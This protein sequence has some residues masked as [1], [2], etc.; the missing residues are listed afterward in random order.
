ME[1]IENIKHSIKK[2]LIDKDFIKW[3]K[4]S[5]NLLVS[6]FE[7]NEY[8]ELYNSNLELLD[9][10]IIWM[11]DNN[12]DK[13]EFKNRYSYDILVELYTLIKRDLYYDIKYNYIKQLNNFEQYSNKNINSFEQYSNKNI[14]SFEQN[15]NNLY[16]YD[17]ILFI[18]FVIGLIIIIIIRLIYYYYKNNNN[19]YQIQKP[20]PKYNF[21]LTLNLKDDIVKDGLKSFIPENNILRES[22][23][24]F[25]IDYNTILH[26]FNI[27]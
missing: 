25:G 24:L 8:K 13:F 21:N 14:N 7:Y 11:K 26:K 27:L 3:N 5:I 22:M 9:K 23:K 2:N 18:I 19:I 12:F 15:S 4:E 10:Y 1:S 20:D 6:I 17:Y 16:I